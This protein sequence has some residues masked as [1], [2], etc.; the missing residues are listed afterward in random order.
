MATQAR[1][2]YEILGV[3]MRGRTPSST[4]RGVVS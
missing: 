2:L 4:P 3:P 1:D